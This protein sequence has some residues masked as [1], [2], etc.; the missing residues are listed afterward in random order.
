MPAVNEPKD[1]GA[2][3]VS[4]SVAG[5]EPPTLPF[6]FTAGMTVKERVATVSLPA[7]S[8]AVT[9]SVNV[10]G[11]LVSRFDPLAVEPA[12]EATPAPPASAQVNPAGT[13]RPWVYTAPSVAGVVNATVGA[14]WSTMN[15]CDR[16]AS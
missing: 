4:D 3:S 8:R 14:V 6:V 12:H 2:P 1:A 7:A 15:V 5:T 16:A 13:G 11:V 10:P 9:V